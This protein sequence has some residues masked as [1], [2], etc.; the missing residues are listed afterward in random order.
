MACR[1][2]KSLAAPHFLYS[3]G[4]PLLPASASFLIW[5]QPWEPLALEE[6]RSWPRVSCGVEMEDFISLL[7][8]LCIFKPGSHS[9]ALATTSLELTDI[10]LPLP[11]P[12]VVELGVCA[13]RP[14]EALF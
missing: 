13:A 12:A 9:V 7:T 14:H 8:Y 3:H 6:E 4:R 5:S 2:R 10:L 1:P 11:P